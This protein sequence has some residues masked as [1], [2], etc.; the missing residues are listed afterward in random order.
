MSDLFT[1]PGEHNP[2]TQFVAEAVGRLQEPGDP[3]SGFYVLA[4]GTW[5]RCNHSGVIQGYAENI[6]SLRKGSVL[7]RD[8]WT[9][10]CYD[11][12]CE[13]SLRIRSVWAGNPAQVA[14][15]EPK[16]HTDFVV[17]WAEQGEQ[18]VN[19]HGGHMVRTKWQLSVAGVVIA[20]EYEE[21]RWTTDPK[22]RRMYMNVQHA[23]NSMLTLYK[24][25]QAATVGITNGS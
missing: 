8:F 4:G 7:F 18:S 9:V 20:T 6:V 11:D 14:P 10:A 21:H 16:T 17:L 19:T 13:L 24:E 23:P 2:V 1:K 3:Y 12:G 15:V 5:L 22:F 25:L